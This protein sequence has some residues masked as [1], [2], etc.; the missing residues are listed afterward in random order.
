MGA[1][2]NTISI[3]LLSVSQLVLV[4][5]S[6]QAGAGVLYATFWPSSLDVLISCRTRIHRST[7]FR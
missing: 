3:F 5:V 1:Y 6:K 4:L 2:S 7:R